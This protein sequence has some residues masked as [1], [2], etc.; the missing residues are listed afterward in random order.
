MA[1]NRWQIILGAVLLTAVLLT[2]AF[3]LG[4]YV[5]RHGWGEGGLRYQP[6]GPEGG[7]GAQPGDPGGFAAD[8]PDMVGRIRALSQLGI[9]LATQDGPRIVEVSE[10]TRVEDMDGAPLSLTDLRLGGLIAVFGDFT[11][12][13]GRRLIAS[14][15]VLLPE[16]NPQQP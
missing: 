14:R 16:K 7:P 11:P 2:A 4:I 1:E 8:P 15:I 6:S 9:Q 12:G 13:D 10:D 3:S 5:G